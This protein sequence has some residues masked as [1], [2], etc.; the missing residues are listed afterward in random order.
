MLIAY[1]IG[2]SEF[3]SELPNYYRKRKNANVN[4]EVVTTS[5]LSV[6]VD[7]NALLVASMDGGING[8]STDIDKPLENEP[9]RTEIL[10]HQAPLRPAELSTPFPSPSPQMLDGAESVKRE[11]AQVET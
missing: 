10:T 5:V 11:D 4:D 2:T 7:D 8:A 9:T 3:Q 1:S 6:V